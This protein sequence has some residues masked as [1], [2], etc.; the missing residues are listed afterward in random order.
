MKKVLK[1]LVLSLLF[2]SIPAITFCQTTG[3]TGGI[4]KDFLV[5]YVTNFA[6]FSATIIL[7][8]SLVN[9]LVTLK[10]FVKQYLSWGIAG[11]VSVVAYFLKIGMFGEL[12]I[13]LTLL[14]AILFGLGSNGIFDWALVQKILIAVGIEKET[15]PPAK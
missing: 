14:T 8:T 10:G 6:A 15:P 2:L 12:S 1:F 3:D 13:W 5:Q 7:L 11:I 4:V 9:K